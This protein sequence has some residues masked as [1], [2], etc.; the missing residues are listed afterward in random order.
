[1]FAKREVARRTRTDRPYVSSSPSFRAVLWSSDVTLNSGSRRPLP[2][3]AFLEALADCEESSPR[4]H[5]LTAGYAALQLFDLWV[6]HECGTTPPSDL[7]LR[8]VQKRLMLVAPGDPIRR[9]LGHLV[10]VMERE[11]PRRGS[12]EHRLRS[13]EAGRILAAYGK[14]LQ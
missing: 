8:R 3:L 4:W 2:H 10:E 13:Y 12:E 5:A 11:A 7:E 14:L 9:C 1:M 6:E